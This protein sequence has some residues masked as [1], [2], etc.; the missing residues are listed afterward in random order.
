[1]RLTVMGYRDDLGALRTRLTNL[2]LEQDRLQAQKG[3]LDGV[4]ARLTTVQADIASLRE[5]YAQERRLPLLDRISIASPCPANWQDM[6]GDDRVRFCGSCTKNVY[7]ISE[8]TSEEAEKLLSTH[9]GN[10]CVRLFRRRDGSVI[11]ADCPVGHKRKRRRR[12]LAGVL[13]ATSAGLA[14]AAFTDALTMGETQDIEVSMGD[15]PGRRAPRLGKPS[16][17]ESHAFVDSDGPAVVGSATVAAP[18]APMATTLS[19][20]AGQHDEIAAPAATPNNDNPDVAAR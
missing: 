17:V 14:G 13:M 6:V 16:P 2:E 4:C 15:V 11:T 9:E 10:V 19:P 12:L 18:F 5:R 1:M 3:E 7:N 20:S 8:L